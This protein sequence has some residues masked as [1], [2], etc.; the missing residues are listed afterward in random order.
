MPAYFPANLF[1]KQKCFGICMLINPRSQPY[2]LRW[3][4]GAGYV[5]RCNILERLDQSHLY[6]N[7]EVPG[8]TCPGRESN[9]G[10][11]EHSRKEP[12]RQL[13]NRYLEH[14]HMSPRQYDICMNW[15]VKW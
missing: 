8:L 2:G 6:P 12:S 11:S 1:F 5:E 13:V 7:L 15:S 14:L 4:E 9:P 10:L 3:G